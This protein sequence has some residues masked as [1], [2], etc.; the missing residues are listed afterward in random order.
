M[1][2]SVADVLAAARIGEVALV[3]EVCG[4]L[5][6][7]AADAVLA[8]GA[9]PLPRA[10]RLNED[11]HVE[12]VSEPTRPEV[13]E[14]VLRQVLGELLAE[15]RTPFPNLSRVATRDEMRGLASLVT[16]LEAALVPVNRRAA[17]RSL[18]RLSR[19]TLRALERGLIVPD[20]ALPESAPAEVKESP[21][22]QGAPL[23]PAR[24]EE[25]AVTPHLAVSSEL[26][27][28]AKSMEATRGGA[29]DPAS[30]AWREMHRPV[31]SAPQEYPP[32]APAPAAV[33]APVS[34][35]VHPGAAPVLERVEQ[36]SS[37]A[38]LFDPAP[39]E[40]SEP[41]PD[42]IRG[43]PDM[44][45]AEPDPFDDEPT[46]VIAPVEESLTDLIA[47]LRAAGAQVAPIEGEVPDEDF[48]FSVELDESE[49]PPPATIETPRPSWAMPSEAVPPA[50]DRF[51]TARP[52]SDLPPQNPT[53]LIPPSDG[54]RA[55]HSDLE[56]LLSALKPP[57]QPEHLKETLEA[58][59]PSEFP[60]RS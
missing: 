51:R 8:A 18:S 15:V 54:S 42:T 52:R 6:L 32:A 14:K 34:P 27:A 33:P 36:A 28:R 21:L 30:I 35:L 1:S 25:D 37:L 19:E 24:R 39:L 4:Y 20:V 11:G 47:E 3:G 58:L 57:V 2:V 50:L 45:R 16:E 31:P 55:P 60:G 48:E 43:V 40:A 44:A 53:P 38:S 59:S 56:G 22:K 7:G 41:A 17:K 26:A 29:T 13:Q 12:V 23:P 46:I 49:E 9:L 5:V 10:I